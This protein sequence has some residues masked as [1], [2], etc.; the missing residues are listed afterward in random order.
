M[1][2]KKIDPISAKPSRYSKPLPPEAA[3]IFDVPNLYFE[4]FDH[5]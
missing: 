1:A 3:K 5:D 4:T 2:K